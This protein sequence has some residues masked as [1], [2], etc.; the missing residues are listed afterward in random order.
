[1]KGLAAVSK[2]TQ[3]IVCNNKLTWINLYYSIEK[4]TVYTKDGED[5][6]FV[7]YLINPQSGKDIQKAVERWKWM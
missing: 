5:R 2:A 7:T 4:D 6:S 3:N 1:M